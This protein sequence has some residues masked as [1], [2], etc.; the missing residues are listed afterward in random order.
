MKSIKPYILTGS[1]LFSTALFSFIGNSWKQELY[2]ENVPYTMECLPLSY[3][4]NAIHDEKLFSG[5]SCTLNTFAMENSQTINMDTPP[6]FEQ[7]TEP[8]LES[9]EK[10]YKEP[11]KMVNNSLVYKYCILDMAKHC[12]RML[13]NDFIDQNYLNKTFLHISEAECAQLES[14]SDKLLPEKVCITKDNLNKSSKVYIR[15]NS[16]QLSNQKNHPEIEFST[17]TDDYFA[18]AVFIGDSRTVG[19]EAYSNIPNATFLCKTSLTLYDYRKPVIT[20]E[21]E[22]MSIHDVL[23][24][25]KYKKVYFMVGINECSYGENEDYAVAYKEVIEDIR[26]LQP[27]ALIFI[28]GNLLVTEHKSSTSSIHNSR[29]IER[30]EIIHSL[31]NKKDIFYLDI[32]ES[33]LCENGALIPEYTWDEVHIKAEYYTIWKE[34]YL[35]HGI[36]ISNKS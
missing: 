20:F 23:A 11:P 35:S 4:M 33:S 36:I 12:S 1:L 22:K 7:E 10:N 26:T 8:A 28:Q 30:N 6:V 16:F 25:N 15:E 17:V 13:Q 19:I 29:I 21:N 24:K 9:P 5:I 27:E 3:M 2:E 31:E 34:F 32:N 18:D 14:I